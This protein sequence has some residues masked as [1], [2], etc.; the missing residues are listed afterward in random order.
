[1]DIVTG[2][3]GRV[4]LHNPVDFRD[5]QPSRSNISTQEDPGRCVNELEERVRTLL[6]FLFTLFYNCQ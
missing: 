4:K 6:L 3:V 2:I 1:M 5:I